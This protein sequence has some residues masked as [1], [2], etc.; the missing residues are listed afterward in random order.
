MKVMLARYRA[1][2]GRG[3]VVEDALRSMAEAV[4]Q[5]EPA[6][7]SY[8]AARSTE[9]G[10]VFVLY[11]VYESEQALLAHRETPHYR[12]L[13]EE[14]VAPLLVSRERE[15]LVPLHDASSRSQDDR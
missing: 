7:L 11:E 2:P 15:I 4:A 8:R 10:D 14:I 6:C 1:H 13:I 12:E 5:D 9:D 3:N